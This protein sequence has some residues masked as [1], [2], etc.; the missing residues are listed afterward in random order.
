[1]AATIFTFPQ[2][3]SAAA[4]FPMSELKALM[5]A[6]GASRATRTT[7]TNFGGIQ[8]VISCAE[9]GQVV[10]TEH[11]VSRHHALRD[12]D[13]AV[14]MLAWRAA[15]WLTRGGDADDATD[16]DL[17]ECQYARDQLEAAGDVAGAAGLPHAASE[18]HGLADRVTDEVVNPLYGAV[19]L[20]APTERRHVGKDCL[21]CRG[22]F[23][24]TG[25]SNWVCVGCT[26]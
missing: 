16:A 19:G 8:A 5:G 17:K 18:W 25:C 26:N 23:R 10:G 7:L 3:V 14:S 11:Q 6:P 15:R 9:R 13:A 21:R 4:Y 24:S 12:A 1:M 2:P 20:D 22:A